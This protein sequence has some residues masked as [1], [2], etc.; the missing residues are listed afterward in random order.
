LMFHPRNADDFAEFI[1]LKNTGSVPLDCSGLRLS[2][3]SN[4][5]SFTFPEKTFIAAGA[6]F[7]LIRDIPGFRSI[8]PTAA[9]DGIYSGKLDNSAVEDIRLQR[10]GALAA[11]AVY[12]TAAPWQVVPDNHGYFPNDGVGFSLVRQSFDPNAEPTDH[13]Q[14]R[15]SSQRFGSPGADDPPSPV[16]PIY[17]NELLT[18][19]AAGVPDAIEFYNPNAQPADLGG[20]WLS[21]ERNSP[22]KYKIPAG[23]TIPAKGYLVIDETQYGSGV[24][25]NSDGERCYLFS[26]DADGKLTGYSHGLQFSGSDRDVSFGRYLAS[27]GSESFPAQIAK[28]FGSSNSGP[29]IPPVVINEV[30]YHPETAGE[31]YVELYNTTEAPVQLWDPDLTTST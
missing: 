22:Y 7:V 16:P 9:Y 18:R 2:I 24:G 29:R 25:F 19:G 20:W 11:A 13:R 15:A 21:D 5:N 1:E 31:E 12:D 4:T 26:G 28:S 6:F 23:T 17:I 30:M 3:L 8:H 27:D 10:N 14:W